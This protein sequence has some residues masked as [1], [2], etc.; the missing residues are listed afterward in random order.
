MGTNAKI[1]AALMLGVVAF[2][3]LFALGEGVHIP[4]SVP[5]AELVHGAIFVAGMGLY[6]L[7]T[8][9]WLTRGE[10]RPLLRQW[11][12]ILALGTPLLATVIVALVVEPNKG[13]VAEVAAVW[14]LGILCS[15]LGAW[16]GGRAKHA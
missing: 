16:L 4:P 13:A 14:L 9:Y 1:V 6:F 2:F 12:V 8:A 7:L 5:A 11:P 3:L 15:C 10:A